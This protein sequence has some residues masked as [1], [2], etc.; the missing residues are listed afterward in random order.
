MDYGC[1]APAVVFI[2]V[3]RRQGV[4]ITIAESREPMGAHKK[5]HGRKISQIPSVA[6]R[7]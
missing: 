3:Y 5:V 6:K 1:Y 4:D 2:D 7:W